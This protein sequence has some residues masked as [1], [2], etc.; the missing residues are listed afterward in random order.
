MQKAITKAV[1]E[2]KSKE[3]PNE[4]APNQAPTL[5]NVSVSSDTLYEYGNN[6][7]AIGAGRLRNVEFSVSA[8]DPENKDIFIEINGQLYTSDTTSLSMTLANGEW[9]EFRVRAFD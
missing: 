7:Y 4:T 9:R 3:T 6:N 2:S 8:K 1:E 5:E